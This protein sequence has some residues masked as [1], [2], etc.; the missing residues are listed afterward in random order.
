MA[1]PHMMMI[2]LTNQLVLSPDSFKRNRPQAKKPLLFKLEN[3]CQER[4]N[5]YTSLATCRL[6]VGECWIFLHASIAIREGLLR[7]TVHYL[8]VIALHQLAAASCCR[9]LQD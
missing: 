7:F 4:P 3:F 1:S 2:V 6:V 8:M 9:S 5:E